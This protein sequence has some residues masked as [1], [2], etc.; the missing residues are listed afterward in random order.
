MRFVE[1]LQHQAELARSWLSRA[2]GE[3]DDF[4]ADAMAARL[5]DLRELAERNG[6]TLEAA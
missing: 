2:E 6:V 3:Q 1:E 4:L 5:L